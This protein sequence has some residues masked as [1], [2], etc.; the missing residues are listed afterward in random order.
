[1]KHIP[2]PT[3]TSNEEINKAFHNFTNRT[4][5]Q[6][7]FSKQL[8]T[9]TEENDDN[10]HQFEPNLKVKKEIIKPCYFVANNHPLR[11]TC[12]D[13]SQFLQTYTEN[14][15]TTVKKCNTITSIK[16]IQSK[17]P[18]IVFKP[19]D[20][21][22]GL[23]ALN[24]E[25]YDSLIL[26]H[27]NNDLNYKLVSDT[28][29]TT[30]S[31]LKQLISNFNNFKE[32]FTWYSWEKQCINYEYDFKWPK[33][34]CLP[35][36][37]KKG[38]L[39]G[40]PIAG[41]VEWITTPISRIL[42]NRLQKELHRYPCI[43]KNSTTLVKD[44][45][46]FNTTH[47]INNPDI[48]I[49]TGD[50]ESLY[51]NMNLDTLYSIIE[52]IE[53]TCRP[54]TEFICQHS[55]ITYNDHIYHQIQ[56]IPMGTNAAVTLANVYVG[57]LI[58]D[59]INSRPQTLWY[60]RYIDDLFILWTGTTEQWDLVKSFIQRLLKIPINWETPSKNHSIFLDLNI[61]RNTFNG[62]F[63]TSIYQK[64]LNKYH[65]ISPL[66][67]H[68]PHMFT[69][70]IKGELTRYCRLSSNPFTYN[71]TKELFYQRLIQ[72][73]YPRKMLN[74]LFKQHKWTARFDQHDPPLGTILPFVL[75]YTFRNNINVI[76]NYLK[77]NAEFF[78]KWFPYARII[79][80]HSK[81]ANIN[82]ILCLSELSDQQKSFLRSRNSRTQNTTFNPL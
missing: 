77:D 59:Y 16:A 19:A 58:D 2:I 22:L 27:L 78:T 10:Y 17:F 30:R 34:Y 37:H 60:K 54:L 23:C 20:K 28:G 67:S 56:G 53:I 6:Y 73:G 71:H 65:Y 76:Q 68:A 11:V 62:Y 26:T 9:E 64:P 79:F 14:N 55:Y 49:I 31:L 46:E 70:F 80:A 18:H 63:T 72:R 40:R 69:G 12:H 43:L 48:L 29:P 44:L 51:P 81:R 39:K 35:K 5:W 42:N 3:D 15:P 61:T 66:S 8:I 45:M 7:H 4:L 82:N 57:E 36:L 1:M 41:Q 21:N 50:I 75:P 24:I 25:D 38:K 47:F 32:D 52:R 74:R 33:F 13:F